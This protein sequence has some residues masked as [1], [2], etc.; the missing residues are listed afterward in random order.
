MFPEMELKVLA[1]G[2]SLSSYELITSYKNVK[3]DF[4]VKADAI[5]LPACLA[6]MVSKYLR[7]QLMGCINNYFVEKCRNLKPTAG[8]WTDGKRFINDLKQ[9]APE[10][11][12][13][14]NQ[15]IRCR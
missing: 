1:E 6:S 15:L 11:Q 9:I 13:D 2:E 3:I 12:Y 4:A 7:E 14:P 10:I 5:F 8:Y